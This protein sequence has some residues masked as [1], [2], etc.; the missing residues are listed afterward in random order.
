ML[1][2]SDVLDISG[3]TIDEKMTSEKHHHS[4]SIAASHR[5]DILREFCLVIYDLQLLVSDRSPRIYP[6]SF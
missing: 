5:L 4:V 3:V 1:K 2:E 6:A